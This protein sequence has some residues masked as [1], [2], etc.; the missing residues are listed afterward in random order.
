MF[1]QLLNPEIQQYIHDNAK[2]DVTK[3]AL[4]KPIFPNISNRDLVEQIEGLQKVKDKI[5]SWLNIQGIVYPPRLSME[6]CSSEATAKYKNSIINGTSLLDMTGGFGIDDA[7]LSK[8]FKKIIYFEQNQDLRDIVQHNF[9]TLNLNAIEC[10]CGNS[11]E[12]LEQNPSTKF[13]WIYMDP[14]RRDLYGKRVFSLENCTPNIIENLPLLFKHS[15]NILIKTAPLLDIK[16]AIFELKYV[17]EVHVLAIK[18]EVREVLYVL[19]NNFKEEPSVFA[20]NIVNNQQDNLKF[21]YSEERELIPTF[22]KPQT[23]LYEPNGAILKSG[24]FNI[25]CKKFNI[26]KLHIN[27]HLYTSNSFVKNFQGRSF[28][29]AKVL[30]FGKHAQ[31]EISE[32]KYANITIRNFP[33]TVENLRKKLKIKEGG[34]NYLFF[35]TLLDNQKVVI[36]CKKI[37]N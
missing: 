8:N 21:C 6:Q 15:N 3:L 32:L 18:N 29:I 4:S 7:F 2:L 5:P 26:N 1:S 10:F 30:D 12:Y 17:K 33:N 11:I 28:E 24:G 31:R 9:K 35:T 34:E 14:V 22:T 19:E 27:T 23:F 36:I 20:V 37:N 16:Q 25:I 13:D